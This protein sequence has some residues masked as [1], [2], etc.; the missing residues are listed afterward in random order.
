MTYLLLGE[1][2]LAKDQKII[3]L[4]EEI[5]PSADALAFDYESLDGVEVDARALRKA[6]LALPVIGHAD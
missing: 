6:F 3:E 4:K 5:L 1:D 2:S